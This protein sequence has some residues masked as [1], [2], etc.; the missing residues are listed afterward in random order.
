MPFPYTRFGMHL[1][2]DG[3]L[4]AD[5]QNLNRRP[6]KDPPRLPP[7]PPIRPPIL[8]A[9]RLCPPILP[10]NPILRPPIIPPR[11]GPPKPP[12][13]EPNRCAAASATNPNIDCSTVTDVECRSELWRPILIE[14]CPNV[15]GLC[16][17]KRYQQIRELLKNG[18]EITLEILLKL[19]RPDVENMIED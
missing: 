2:S 6:P 10:P 8:P 3:H 12:K 16:T 17:A 11:R 18:S 13:L 1:I 5:K 4:G 14:E 19:E 7:N 9:N 15:C